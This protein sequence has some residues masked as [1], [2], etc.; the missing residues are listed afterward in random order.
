MTLGE[1]ICQVSKLL[2]SGDL[3]REGHELL[4]LASDG[5]VVV[6]EG[7]MRRPTAAR[8]VTRYIAAHPTPD[9]W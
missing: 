4:G 1:A 3:V 5:T 9:T 8:D 2:A 6:I 7:D